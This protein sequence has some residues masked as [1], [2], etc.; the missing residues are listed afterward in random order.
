MCAIIGWSGLMPKGLLSKLLVQAESRGKDSVGMAYRVDGKNVCYRHAVPAREFVTSSEKLVGEARRSLRGLAHTRRASPNM[1]VD[2]ANAHP[3]GFWKYFFAHNGR[4]T[5]WQELKNALVIR[6]Q[7]AY[8]D[9]LAALGQLS[10]DRAAVDAALAH[11]VTPVDKDKR[12]AGLDDNLTML[13]A[14]PGYDALYAAAYCVDYARKITT[15]SM[16]LGPYIDTRDLSGVVGCMG[17]V[18][19]RGNSVYAF[20]HGKEATAATIV[21]KY[22][23]PKAN[24]PSGDQVVTVVASTQE[25]I[26]LALA[27]MDSKVVEF[28]FSFFDFPENTVFRIE[29]SGLETEGQI[30]VNQVV[31]EDAWSSGR[32]ETATPASSVPADACP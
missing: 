9:A 12:P 2:N 13:K 15:D 4:I 10:I 23:S 18:W 31:V 32:V 28:S 21:W 22:L 25:I 14:I 8:E 27:A 6:Y 26:S 11:A 3:F 1:P 20:R 5:N 30:P 24:E 19:M 29:P 17:L 7:T 16:V